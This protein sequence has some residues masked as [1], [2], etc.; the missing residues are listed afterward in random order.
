MLTFDP[1][2]AIN[3]V[4]AGITSVRTDVIEPTQ[5]VSYCLKNAGG[6]LA[7]RFVRL[8]AILGAYIRRYYGVTL[9]LTPCPRITA[10][11]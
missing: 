1:L 2:P 8:S 6:G 7:D 3:G 10:L 9:R 11:R 5:N 4:I